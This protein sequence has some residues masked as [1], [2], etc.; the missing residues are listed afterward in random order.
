MT[1]AELLSKTDR[2]I[3]KLATFLP[4]FLYTGIYSYGRKFFLNR[5]CNEEPKPFRAAKH[6]SV[7][8]WDIEFSVPLFN[9]AGMF[10]TGD[11]YR[12][13]A[14]QGAGAYLAGTTTSVARKGNRKKAIIHPFV[15]LPRSGTA[16]NWMG[17]PNPGNEI[18]AKKLSKV[19]KIQGC[20]IGTSL[21][22]S[23]DL[24][25]M[26]A[27]YGCVEGLK[28][29]EKANV[30]FIELNESCPNLEAHNNLS[31]DIISDLI[32]RLEFISSNYLRKRMRNL[33]V[34]VKFSIDTE[35]ELLYLLIDALL[36]LGFDGINFGNTSTNYNLFL[37]EIDTKEK[38]IYSYFYQT[39]GGGIS[40]KPLKEKS[41][42][43]CSSAVK[44]LER[45][46]LSKEFYVIRTGGIENLEDIL[47]SKKNGI[48]L[49]QWF[50]GYFENFS[51]YGHR[52]YR[53]LF[54]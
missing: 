32:Y 25:N 2:S 48:L 3:R 31:K 19:E 22:N 8:L 10:K 35:I 16:L 36:D 39:F 14:L 12:T 51:K 47:L 50:T 20:P 54:T 43:L 24:S 30:D 42:L 33:P 17:L 1:T 13:I 18:L 11:G 23:P 21:S 6:H 34:I 7:K 4:S 9:S 41:L 44:Y 45:K 46:N 5:F 15:P 49:N 53:E 27:L 26:D 38:K 40:G 37:D 52:V 28:L 29:F